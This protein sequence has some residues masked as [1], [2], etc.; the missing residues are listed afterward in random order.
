MYNLGNIDLLK[1]SHHGSNTSS[2]E[3]FIN[4]INPKYSLISVGASNR[5]GHPKKSVLD[6]LNNS[7]IYR[8]NIDVSIEIKLNRS[9]YKIRTFP[10]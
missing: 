7:T 9:G 8:T 1:V 3:S 4:H 6:I 5:Y 2:E 10:P